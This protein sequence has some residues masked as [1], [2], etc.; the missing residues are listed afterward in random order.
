MKINIYHYESNKVYVSLEIEDFDDWRKLDSII[1]MLA[2]IRVA[3]KTELFEVGN[4]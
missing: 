1:D 3:M 2:E 4:T